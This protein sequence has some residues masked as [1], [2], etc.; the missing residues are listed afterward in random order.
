MK[1]QALGRGLGALL[2]EIDEAY[3]NEVPK[4]ILL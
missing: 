2:G 1:S 4:K 3:D